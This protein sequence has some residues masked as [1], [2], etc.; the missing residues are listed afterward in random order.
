MTDVKKAGQE[1]REGIKEIAKQ[2]RKDFDDLKKAVDEKRELHDAEMERGKERIKAEI[3]Y[4]ET[5][6]QL[7]KEVEDETKELKKLADEE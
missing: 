3:E 1:I 7:K 5:V 2:S 6:K 4:I